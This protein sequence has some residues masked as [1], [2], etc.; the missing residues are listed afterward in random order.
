MTRITR[1]P[2]ALA[3]AFALVLSLAAVE[4]AG[5][6]A[7]ATG[8]GIRITDPKGGPVAQATITLTFNGETK[9][10]ET[11][12]D[13]LVAIVW[14]G[15]GAAVKAG[16][17]VLVGDGT[18]T[19]VYPGG[20]A[21]GDTF[22]AKDGVITFV[23]SAASAPAKTGLSKNAKIGIAA[24]VAVVGVGAAAAGGSTSAAQGPAP[25]PSTAPAPGPSA[26]PTNQQP[27]QSAFGFYGVNLV[28]IDNPRD[29]HQFVRAD[30]VSQLEVTGVA[31]MM[32]AGAATVTFS[33]PAPWVGVGG[34]W[35]PATGRFS[36]TGRGRVAGNPNIRCDFN[37]TLTA[38]GELEGDY[39][40]GVG[41]GLPGGGTVT[42]RVTGRKN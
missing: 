34:E 2:V 18:G 37:G 36:A 21:G 11:D 16:A 24:G 27:G 30:Q 26:P 5:A 17:V 31:T 8:A 39:V 12:D 29:H 41:G 10:A 4:P 6:V 1:R 25:Q 38:S 32:S 9:T 23:P 7:T 3:I 40:M 22:T 14:G 19:V 28:C 42:Y 33:G 15:S 35:D 13:G 20:P